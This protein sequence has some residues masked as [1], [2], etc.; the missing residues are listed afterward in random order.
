MSDTTSLGYAM[1][2]QPTSVPQTFMHSSGT[3]Q[4][5][6]SAGGET[7]TQTHTWWLFHHSL[8]IVSYSENNNKWSV[9]LKDGCEPQTGV[10]DPADH[11]GEHHEEHGQQFEVATHDAAGLHVGQTSS[12]EAPLHYH[13]QRDQDSIGYLET[14]QVSNKAEQEENILLR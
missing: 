4:P 3:T 7:Q 8:V 13:L 11:A 10:E 2:E 12:C 14:R 9:M 5:T 1:L 6:S